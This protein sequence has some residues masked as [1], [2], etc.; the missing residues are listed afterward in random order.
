MINFIKK[1]SNLICS[2]IFA[3][4][5]VLSITEIAYYSTKVVSASGIIMNTLNLLIF[6]GIIA[7][8]VT[9]NKRLI[10]ALVLT[11][12]AWDGT[13][14][15]VNALPNMFSVNLNFAGTACLNSLAYILMA[16]AIILV[17]VAS[18]TI[19]AGFILDKNFNKYASYLYLAAA[20]LM[21]IAFILTSIFL[22]TKSKVVNAS[23][24]EALLKF[25]IFAG[26]AFGLYEFE[27]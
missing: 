15:L 20:S 19:L 9:N 7:G 1:Y 4:G 23:S 11:L 12:I 24:V 27:K 26:C 17:V 8:C 3:I 16:I 5:V 22:F 21:L 25:C 2:I 10:K 18:L 6:G 14:Y 13:A